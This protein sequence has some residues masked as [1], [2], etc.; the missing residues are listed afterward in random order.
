[1]FKVYSEFSQIDRV[2]VGVDSFVHLEEIVECL[3]MIAQILRDLWRV[4]N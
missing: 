1:M 2:I 4:M 3:V